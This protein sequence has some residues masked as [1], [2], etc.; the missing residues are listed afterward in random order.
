MAWIV[1]DLDNCLVEDHVDEMTGE[2][3]GSMPV[4]GALEAV[5]TLMG[6]GHRL[7]VHTSRFAPMPETERN[8]LKEQIEQELTAAGFP[9][10]EIWTGTTKPAADIF[11]SD[12]NVT[13]D[14]DWGLVL[15]QTQ[16]ML[17]DRGLIPQPGEMMEGEGDEGME[18]AEEIQAG[19]EEQPPE[20]G[21]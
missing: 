19:D 3:G 5:Q 13:F 20:E 17:E 11:I 10:L 21:P 6:E 4:D 12:N 16:Q 2:E 9:P 8:R 15:A 14:G 1:F 18:G 7:T